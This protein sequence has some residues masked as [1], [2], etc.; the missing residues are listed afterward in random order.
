[1]SK[2]NLNP[3][4][5]INELRGGSV[6]FQPKKTISPPPLDKPPRVSPSV[7][8][9]TKSQSYRVTDLQSLRV[10]ELQ[11]YRLTEFD[12]Y[13][14]PHFREM[15]RSE[16]W[17]TEEQTDFLVALAKLIA[18]KRPEGEKRDPSYKRITQ[19][20]IIRVLV[21]IARRL[22]LTVDARNFKNE[23]DLAK[24]MWEELSYRLTD[25]Q[26]SKVTD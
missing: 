13:E 5:V 22:K 25:L 4:E 1:M 15:E 7:E 26:S 14:V 18:R 6:F 21:E 11:S 24:A 3:E 16:L 12:D 17:L 23:Q 9:P 20:S 19:N 8:A 10:T 2:K